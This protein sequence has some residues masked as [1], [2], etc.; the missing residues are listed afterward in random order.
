M[1][2][3]SS[4]IVEGSVCA[5]YWPTVSITRPSRFER[6]S[7]PTT[8][9]IGFLRPPMRVSLSRTDMSADEGSVLARLPA[10]RVDRDAH[11]RGR[12]VVDVVDV[13]RVDGQELRV[14]AERERGAVP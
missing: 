6:W 7:A 8:R 13:A 2:S 5:L 3:S 10:P 12:A 1:R 4:T 14:L 11:Q 9:Q